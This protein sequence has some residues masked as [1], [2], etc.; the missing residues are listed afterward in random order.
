MA[1]ATAAVERVIATDAHEGPV[2]VVSED[3]LYFT[4][5]RTPGAASRVDIMRLALGTLELT[6]VR[7]DAN[8]A[9]GMA[10]DGRGG[11]IVC[12]QGT[13]T[14]PAA[15]TRLDLETG[16]VHTLVDA[17]L[18]SRL[19]SPNDVVVKS[20]GT[21][22]FTDPSYGHLQGFRPPPHHADQVYRHDPATG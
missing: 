1:V 10:A 15:I 3:A 22:W 4:T 2:Y 8:V 9:N 14:R 11:L 17:F 13:R 21:I 12:E 5:Q 18:G 6:T 16:A 20:D 7:A 19:N